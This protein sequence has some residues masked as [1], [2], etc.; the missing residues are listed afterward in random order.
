[1]TANQLPMD[2][3]VDDPPERIVSLTPSNTEILFALG[4]G[5]RLVGVSHYCDYPPE[6]QALP[7][8]ARF[9]DTDEAAILA[10]QPDLVLTSSHLQKA[11]VER[12]IERDLT[13]LALNP[14]DLTG[15]FRD[16]LLLG[17]LVN[18][19]E[20]A[21]RLVAELHARVVAV[22]DAG[23]ALPYHPRVYLEEWGKPLI[24]AG[25]WLADFI[26]LAGRA[27]A[28]SMVESRPHSRERI[29]EPEAM[30]TADPEVILVS[31]PG[32]RNDVPRQRAC[33]RPEWQQ[34]SAVRHGRVF[35][36]DDRLLHRPGPRLVDGL[37]AIARIVAEVAYALATEGDHVR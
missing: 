12:L 17:Q 6:A 25:W 33:N 16:M 15:V 24:P 2:L 21:Q 26:T 4:A 11:I 9:I 10:L 29:I 30:A 31:W 20:Q 28:L 1:M 23:L 34:V 18:V 32:I 27:A 35:Q 22:V 36:V 7:K 13:V 19:R 5:K 37:E 3:L 14:T 8:V